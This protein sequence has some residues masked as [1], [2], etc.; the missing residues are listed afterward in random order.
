MNGAFHRF[1]AA[2]L[3]LARSGTVKERLQ[4]AYRLQ[5]ADIDSEQLP[6]EVSNRTA[7]IR[8]D[9]IAKD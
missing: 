3:M 7:Y 8:Y 9:F 6:G 5:L 2:A 1:R 4:A